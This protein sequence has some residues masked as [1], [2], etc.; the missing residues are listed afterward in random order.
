MSPAF[1][2]LICTKWCLWDRLIKVYM[3]LLLLI[4]LIV[5]NGVYAID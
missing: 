2:L 3:R 4:Y 5:Q 1:I